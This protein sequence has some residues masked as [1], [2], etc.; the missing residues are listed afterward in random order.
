[1]KYL[2]LYGLLV[3]R[4]ITT[5]INSKSIPSENLVKLYTVV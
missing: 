1:M 4:P 5:Y 2:E 3:L